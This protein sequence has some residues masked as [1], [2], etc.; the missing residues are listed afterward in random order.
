M[1]DMNELFQQEEDKALAQIRTE[2]AEEQKRWDALPQAERDRLNAERQ[3]RLEALF[4]DVGDEA[5]EDED[6]DED[7]GSED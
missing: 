3:T 7:D 6:E 5:S 1:Q 2:M 4:D